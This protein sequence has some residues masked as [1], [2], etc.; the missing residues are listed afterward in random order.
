MGR[1]DVPKLYAGL[2]KKAM[3]GKSRKAAMHVFCAECVGWVCSE[4]KRCADKGCPLYPYRS[5]SEKQVDSDALT[6]SEI[7]KI[8]EDDISPL[9]QPL[10]LPVRAAAFYK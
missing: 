5:L 1:R 8:E 9:L 4:I 10:G 2:Y 7:N 3:S 6:Q